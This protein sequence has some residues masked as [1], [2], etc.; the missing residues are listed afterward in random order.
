VSEPLVQERGGAVRFTVRVQPRAARSKVDGV[1]AGALRVRLTAPPVEGA[2]NEA[3]IVLLAE[4]LG[5]P[6]RAISIVSGATSR[7]KLVEV[8]G[9]TA[10]GVR[11]L[12]AQC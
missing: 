10:A 1:H 11:A 2:A 7:V 5:V 9:V 4:Q 8:E 12:A 6:K 3:L